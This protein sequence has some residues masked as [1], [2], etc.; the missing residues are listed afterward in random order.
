M[1][2]IQSQTAV[3]VAEAM[4]I[5]QRAHEAIWAGDAAVQYFVMAVAIV[6]TV[7]GVATVGQTVSAFP[8]LPAAIAGLAGL[9]KNSIIT[10]TPFVVRRPWK[11]TT[12]TF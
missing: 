4:S 11:S 5:P 8:L 6:P 3:A 12:Y 1:A 7:P 9:P 2:I 10:G